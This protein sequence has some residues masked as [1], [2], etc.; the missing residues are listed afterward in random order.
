MAAEPSNKKPKRSDTA[1]EP[2]A[3]PFST[4]EFRA[5]NAFDKI[6]ACLTTRMPANAAL[7]IKVQLPGRTADCFN[8]TD[9]ER[10][11]TFALTVPGGCRV[12]RDA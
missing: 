4:A 6:K 9:F 2:D 3:L 11:V 1:E 8:N 5:N 10:A 12:E 7:Y